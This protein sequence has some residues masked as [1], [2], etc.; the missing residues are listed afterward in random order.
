MVKAIRKK[1]KF[2]SAWSVRDRAIHFESRLPNITKTFFFKKYE[3][4]EQEV[5]LPEDLPRLECKKAERKT[6]AETQ[7]RDLLD[8]DHTALNT[9]TQEQRFC[10]NTAYFSMRLW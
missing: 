3:K 9:R 10:G 1:Q 7:Q 6:A 5:Q 2:S 8:F 4:N